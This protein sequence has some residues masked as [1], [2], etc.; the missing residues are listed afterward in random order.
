M[1]SSRVIK[2]LAGFGIVGALLTILMIILMLVSP[3]GKV[4]TYLDLVGTLFL[5]FVIIAIYLIHMKN[6]GTWGLISFFI[7]IIGTGLVVGVK[8]VHTFVV[9]ALSVHVPEFV[10]QPPALIIGGQMGSFAVFMLGW[11]LI[12]ILVARKGYLSR[13]SGI[14]LI[15]APILDFIPIGYYV[16]QPLFAIATLWISY[17]LFSGKGADNIQEN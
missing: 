15:I 17:E 11:V 9:P 12:G 5:I 2:W 3:D 1:T 14:L 4:G 8:W 10:D 7:C 6:S 13:I 16:A